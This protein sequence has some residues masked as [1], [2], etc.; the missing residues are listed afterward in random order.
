MGVPHLRNLRKLYLNRNRISQVWPT[1]SLA[2]WLIY[3]KSRRFFIG[4]SWSLISHLPFF[5][6]SSLPVPSLPINLVI[7]FSNCLWLVIV[8]QT[9][10]SEMRQSS[11]PFDHFRY[12][13]FRHSFQNPVVPPS[14]A[15]VVSGDEC[16]LSHS[17]CS[18]CQSERDSYQ[19]EPWIEQ[20]QWGIWSV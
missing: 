7:S 10:H 6:F 1:C 2:S 9:E 12:P 20:H 14:L 4:H 3:F 19:S 5:L 17:L 8:W 15:G 11:D 13:A 16:S 18:T